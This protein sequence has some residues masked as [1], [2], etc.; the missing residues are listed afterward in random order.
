MNRDDRFFD[1]RSRLLN[2]MLKFKNICD[3][4]DRN[5]KV[6]VDEIFYEIYNGN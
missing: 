6:E 4:E 1:L 5:F 2:I 3:E